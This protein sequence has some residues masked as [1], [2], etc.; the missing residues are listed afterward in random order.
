MRK[1]NV[2]PLIEASIVDIDN[3]LDCD[4][5]SIYVNE[6]KNRYDSNIEKRIYTYKYNNKWSGRKLY[7]PAKFP[8]D[9]RTINC[10]SKMIT[11]NKLLIV[12]ILNLE[13]DFGE[14]FLNFMLDDI[15]D[16]IEDYYIYAYTK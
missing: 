11:K 2:Q 13:Q 14:I 9:N 16:I 1:S 10:Y 15:L 4:I 7:F 6:M 5:N 8:E 3:I 12:S